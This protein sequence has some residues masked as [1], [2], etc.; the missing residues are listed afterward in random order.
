ILPIVGTAASQSVVGVTVAG[1]V[2]L[3]SFSSGLLPFSPI[4]HSSG[5]V[6]GER[7]TLRYPEG[8]ITADKICPG[9]REH[10]ALAAKASAEERGFYQD[11]QELLV[12]DEV[13][14]GMMAFPVTFPGAIKMSGGAMNVAQRALNRR[15][16][17]DT[18]HTS[19]T[20]AQY[21]ENVIDG[22]RVG[23]GLR[24]VG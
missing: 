21:Q 9:D 17:F 20:Y 6:V 24:L 19:T 12:E 13:V 18:D 5:F 7:Y 11:P 2:P 14:N 4:E 1:Q 16:E 22:K 10:D 23:N 8:A 3:T 15:I